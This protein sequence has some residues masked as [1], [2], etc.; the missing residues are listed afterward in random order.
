MHLQIKGFC[1]SLKHRQE[2][3]EWEDGSAEVAVA[4][5]F[6]TRP[7]LRQLFRDYKPPMRAV[8]ALPYDCLKSRRH[9]RRHLI[10]F[11]R[12]T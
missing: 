10:S 3:D 12:V 2:K 8:C 4:L 11:G 5:L 6:L 1:I 9:G 7:K